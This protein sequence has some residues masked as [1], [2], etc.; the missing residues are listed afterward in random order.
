MVVG[1]PTISCGRQSKSALLIWKAH[2]PEEGRLGN[3]R[4]EAEQQQREPEE[5][6]ATELTKENAGIMG[7]R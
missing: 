4:Q 3:V 5:T 7:D 6:Q 1:S 2:A